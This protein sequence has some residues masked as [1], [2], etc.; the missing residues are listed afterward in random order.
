MSHKDTT[1][2]TASRTD[3]FEL[4]APFVP[5]SKIPEEELPTVHICK[6]RRDALEICGTKRARDSRG[7][8]D[9]HVRGV[10]GEFALARYYGDPDGV[11]TE[12][13]EYG[14][15]GVDLDILGPVQVKTCGTQVNNPSLLVNTRESLQA[16]HYFLVQ[17]LDRSTYRLIGYAPRLTVRK[18]PVRRIQIDGYA[19]RFRTVDQCALWQPPQ[20]VYKKIPP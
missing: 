2:D 6:Q 14:D 15:G 4:P 3:A 8:I 20:P 17:E 18:A 12:I 7:T 5:V 1:T 9:R 16:E 19:K 13:R 11:D 10:K